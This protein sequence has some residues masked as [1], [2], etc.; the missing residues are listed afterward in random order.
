M[1]V[2]VSEMQGTAVHSRFANGRN[3]VEKSERK[4]LSEDGFN[5]SWPTKLKWYI[6][7]LD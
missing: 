2:T 5:K 6:D 4:E 1:E 3:V 7:P